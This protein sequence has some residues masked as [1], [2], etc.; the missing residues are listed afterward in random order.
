[1]SPFTLPGYGADKRQF[2]TG[3]DASALD[4]FLVQV[5]IYELRILLKNGIPDEALLPGIIDDILL[6]KNF[7]ATH[8]RTRSATSGLELVVVLFIYHAA[9]R[10][11]AHV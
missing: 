8:S 3:H 7:P 1:M 6:R 4:V 11:S 10:S 2:D 5:V 9:F